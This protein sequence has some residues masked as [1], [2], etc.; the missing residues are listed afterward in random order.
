MLYLKK[1]ISGL[2][3][4]ITLVSCGNTNA[5]QELKEPVPRQITTSEQAEAWTVSSGDYDYSASHAGQKVILD[6]P[7]YSQ[8]KYPTG[9]ELV[10]T[11]MALAYTGTMI[12]AQELVTEGYIE[13]VDFYSKKGDKTL[14][15]GDPNKVFIGDPL[16]EDGYGCFSGAIVSALEKLLPSNKYEVKDL[17]GTE[18]NDLCRLYIDKDIPVIVWASLDM[19]PTFRSEKNSWT[20]EETGEKFTWI[21]NEHCLVL[22]GYDDDNYYFNDPQKGSGTPYKRKVAEKRYKE[23]NQQAVAVI[24]K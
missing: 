1:I 6:V 21:S 8:K 19:K 17:T 14:Y 23:L 16:K 4:V 9:C 2:A 5:G 22:V 12:T 24:E 13:A 7:Y 3:A 10:S 11:S 15:G 20:I 18:L